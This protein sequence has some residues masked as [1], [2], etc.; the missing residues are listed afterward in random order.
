MERL[1][2]TEGM[3][4][5]ATQSVPLKRLGAPSDIANAC[6][7]LA[8]SMAAY[9]NGVVLPVDGGWAQGGVAALGSSLGELLRP[10]S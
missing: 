4:Q 2:P 8:S 5:A 1:A 7:F 9:V 10:Q 3:R 6:I